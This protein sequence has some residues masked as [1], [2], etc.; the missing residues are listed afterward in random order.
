ME[1]AALEIPTQ[2]LVHLD[3]GGLGVWECWDQHSLAENVECAGARTERLEGG[4]RKMLNVQRS[5]LTAALRRLS[6]G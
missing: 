2:P 4:R 3:Q 6:S 5:T 1:D